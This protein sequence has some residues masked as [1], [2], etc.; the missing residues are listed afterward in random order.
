MLGCDRLI[1]C[2]SDRLTATFSPHHV[3]VN[4]DVV[5]QGLEVF[6]S[7]CQSACRFDWQ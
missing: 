6:W 7:G 1:G 5:L 4:K 2:V 3:C